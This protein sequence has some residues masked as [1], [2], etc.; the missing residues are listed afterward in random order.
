MDW[1]SIDRRTFVALLAGALAAP[2]LAQGTLALP[3]AERPAIAEATSGFGP[4][5]TITSEGVYPDGRLFNSTD[6]LKFVDDNHAV[7]T[8]KNREVDEHPLPDVEINL[9]RKAKDR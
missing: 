7:W 9:A 5:A 3:E 8:S 4:Y 2:R 1:A 6:T